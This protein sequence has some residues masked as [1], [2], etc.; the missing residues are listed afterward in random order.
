[1]SLEF[2]EPGRLPASEAL[3]SDSLRSKQHLKR[4]IEEMSKSCTLDF[5]TDFKNK[6]RDI[7]DIKAGGHNRHSKWK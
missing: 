1:M 4:P 3:E 7:P 6:Q 5:R 2:L